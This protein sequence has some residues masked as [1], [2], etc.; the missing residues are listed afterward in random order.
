MDLALLKKMLVAL[1]CPV[2]KS[3]EMA[4]QLDKRAQQLSAERGDSYDQSLAYLV[5]LM[6]QGWAARE[7][8]F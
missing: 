2:D 5:G 6:R 1:G 3:D 4:V 7:R 8:G